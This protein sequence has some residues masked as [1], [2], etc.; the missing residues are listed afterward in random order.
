MIN[1]HKAIL[2]NLFT[3]LFLGAVSVVSAPVAH[4]QF[5]C[6][7]GDDE[8]DVGINICGDTPSDPN[9]IFDALGSIV[10]FLAAGVGIVITLMVVFAGFQY[11][12]SA[13]N[14]DG[15]AA[16]K[17]KLTHAFE[18]LLLFIF[19]TVILNFAIPGGII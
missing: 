13:G 18:A 16:A 9:P 6:G 10:Q 11:I 12:V 3:A 4:A 1:T 19:M 7:S 14:P 17:K 2:L 5:T 8:V 15:I